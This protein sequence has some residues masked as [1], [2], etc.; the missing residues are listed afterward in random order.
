[1]YSANKTTWTNLGDPIAVSV[2]SWGFNSVDLGSLA[3]NNYYLAFGAF[4]VSGG[5]T[6]NVYLDHVTGPDV[7]PILPSAATNP[8]PADQDSFIPTDP[9]LAWDPLIWGGIPS[10]YKVYFGTSPDPTTL[11]YNGANEFHQVGP[12]QLN[13][14]YYWKVIPYNVLGDATD[15]PVWSFTTVPEGGVQI[16]RENDAYQYLPIHTEGDFSY[17]QTLYLQPEIDFSEKRIEKIYYQWNGFE[18]GTLYKDWVIYMGHTSDNYFTSATDWI[19]F[20]NL[21]QVFDGEVAIPNVEGWV[22]IIL[23]TPFEYNNTDN[24]VIAVDEN[25]FGA[26]SSDA[27]FYG[28]E[29]PTVRGLMYYDYGFNPDP[30]SPPLADNLSAGIANIRLQCED[31][32]TGP[33]FRVNPASR[34][35]GNVP[36][37][38]ESD[39]Q[40]FSIKNYGIGT[41]AILGVSKT[42]TDA[43]LFQLTDVNSYPVNLTA[44][45]SIT[46]S[47]TFNPVEEGLKTAS[48][49]ITHDA[50]GSPA[51]V[52]LT[53]TGLDITVSDFPFTETF[54]NNS[55]SRSAWTQ[56]REFGEGNWTFATGAGD[57]SINTAHS[58]VLNARFTSSE[59]GFITKLV[60]PIFDLTAVT[61]PQVEFWYGQEYWSPDQNEL[62]IYYR[63]A[64]DQ[65]WVQL[66]YDNT[67]RDA[68]TADTLTLPN[69]S[70]TYQ[71]AFEG[72]DNYGY[73]NVLDDV[74]VGPPAGLMTVWYG[75]VSDDWTDPANWSAGVPG[76]NHEVI[77]M[78]GTFDATILTAVTINKITLSTGAYLI[79]APPGSLT[80]T[81]N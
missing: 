19:P 12:L 1:M 54:E 33:V 34:D 15:C 51:L 11:V 70:A 38:S 60:S 68:W 36:I 13:T 59:N 52:P 18:D 66:F 17:T 43:G 79:I 7:V 27:Y 21:T 77:I 65:P 58:G 6:I 24:L 71:L 16:G 4:N 41:L 56:I 10:G 30:A 26:G 47:V 64:Q 63:T 40:V 22:E 81:G 20:A 29:Y 35:Y 37:A 73:P 69:P 48:L 44:N 14:I 39:P 62:I 25:T 80:V 3:G 53:G 72:I 42:G 45:Q 55:L 78:P 2:A 28:T 9:A 61:N 5:N 23:D 32:P 46:V 8:D 31:V 50:S 49:S 74:T 67:D 57:G 76:T 75:N